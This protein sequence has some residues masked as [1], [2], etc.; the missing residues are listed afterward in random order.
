MCGQAEVSV[1]LTSTSPPTRKKPRSSRRN[2]VP[3]ARSRGMP[4]SRG[5]R[6]PSSA[7]REAGGDSRARGRAWPCPLLARRRLVQVLTSAGV[8]G[9]DSLDVTVGRRADPHVL[10]C[11]RDHQRHAPGALV[12]AQ[13]FAVLVDVDEPLALPP[14]CPAGRVGRDVAQPRHAGNPSPDAADYSRKFSK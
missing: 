14:P 12:G 7:P 11:G 4:G 2:A 6:R 10:P 9:A 5:A 8:V 1:V 13:A 3:S